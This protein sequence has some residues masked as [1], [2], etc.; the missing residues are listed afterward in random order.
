M[1]KKIN[2]LKI[3]FYIIFN[4]PYYYFHV[5]IGII[6][7]KYYKKNL[8]SVFSKTSIEWNFNSSN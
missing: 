6:V 8:K 2:I 3:K 5:F 4:K 7:N 1:Y